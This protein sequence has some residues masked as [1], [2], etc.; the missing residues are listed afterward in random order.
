MVTGALATWLDSGL[1]PEAV[2]DLVP[3]KPLSNA[4]P[5]VVAACRDALPALHAKI[6]TRDRRRV[7]VRRP[8]A[9]TEVLMVVLFACVHNAGRSQ[10]AAALF[11]LEA[12]PRK[13]GRSRPGT[14]P[15]SQVHP[16][17]LEA[18][19][20]LGVDLAPVQPAAAHRGTR[21]PGAGADHDGLR[22]RLPG[23]ARRR[24]R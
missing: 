6:R 15:G 12:D 13:P 4:E 10:M 22:R 7:E 5:A 1:S 20:E 9:H 11:N 18:M 17:V 2:M 14:Q 19:R 16:E 24:A 3:V 23:G 8:L 21:A